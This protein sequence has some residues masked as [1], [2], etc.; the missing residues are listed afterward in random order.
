MIGIGLAAMAL[1]SLTRGG[2][3]RSSRWCD[4]EL[5]R[6][7]TAGTWLFVYQDALRRSRSV[8]IALVEDEATAE[9]TRA[10]LRRA[11]AED[12]DT[13][14]ERWWIGLR[15]AEREHYR[16]DGDE[17]TADETAYR[18]GFEAALHP[19]TRGKSWDQALGRNGARNSEAAAFR[20]GF[21]RGRAYRQRLVT[22]E[23]H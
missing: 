12:I 4:R 9:R 15:D 5:A 8:L 23:R 1:L 17:F 11:G 2:G 13:A 7:R 3:G 14:R 19:E 18:R 16:A 6:G 10:L 20:R 22:A 21:E